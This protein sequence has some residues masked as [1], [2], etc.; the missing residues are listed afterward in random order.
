MMTE[1]REGTP[2]APRRSYRFD[3]L[4]PG[5][6]QVITDPDD[7]EKARTAAYMFQSRHKGV[8]MRT[9]TTDAGLEIWRIT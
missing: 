6:C 1:L 4:K 9:R 8:E 2:P 3:Q 7:F 5:Q